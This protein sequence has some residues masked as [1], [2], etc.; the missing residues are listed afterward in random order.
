MVQS[1]V[2]PVKGAV[3]GLNYGLNN[4]RF[5]TPVRAGKR[6]RGRFRLKDFAERA[7]GQ[8]LSTIDVTMEIEGEERPALAAEWIIM[9][10]LPAA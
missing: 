10:T 1:T 8:W 9:T 7:P 2:P 3:L 6:V 5:L 4:L